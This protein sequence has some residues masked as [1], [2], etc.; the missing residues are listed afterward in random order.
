M[1]VIL[2]D[3]STTENSPHLC[4]LEWVGMQGIDLPVKVAEPGYERDLH[5]RV[6]LQVDLPVPHVKGIHMSRLY[7]LLNEGLGGKEVLSPAS[8]QALLKGMIETHS[9]CGSESARIKLEFNLLV[10]RG[11]LLTEGL[12]GWKSYPIGIV[13]TIVRDEFSLRVEAK[14]EYSSTCPCSAALSRQFVQDR[15]LE[16]FQGKDVLDVSAVS[17]WL[18]ENA[19]LATPHSQRSEA[20]VAVTIDGPEAT[21]L[22]LIPLIERIEDAVETPVQTAVKRADEQAFAALNGQNLMFVED[23]ARRIDAAL[24]DYSNPEVFVRHIE[25]LHPHDAV[26]WSGTRS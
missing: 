10:R 3:I 13:S 7:L 22:G 8:I 19:T 9:D 2:P 26:A 6:D 1:N 17:E 20:I 14:V 15:F 4:P 16:A 18:N 12:A 5:A 24:T 11:A 25:S 21:E 23:A